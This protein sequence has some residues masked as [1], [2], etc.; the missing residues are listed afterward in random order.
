MIVGELYKIG[1]DE[2]LQQCVLSHEQEHVLEEAHVEVVGGHYGGHATVR[3]ELC[4]VIWYPNL[5]GNATDYV[6][7]CDVCQRTRNPS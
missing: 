4:I 6:W 3:K 1:H 7:T 2:N 5:N